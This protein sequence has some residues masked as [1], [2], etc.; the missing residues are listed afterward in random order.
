MTSRTK[1]KF[2]GVACDICHKGF[3][4]VVLVDDNE[5]SWHNVEP[6][7][8]C[9]WCKADIDLSGLTIDNKTCK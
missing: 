3:Y 1:F 6:R 9:I 4:V 8:N 5:I 2:K 7:C